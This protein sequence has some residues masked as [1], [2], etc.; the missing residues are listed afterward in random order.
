MCV[1]FQFLGHRSD[2]GQSAM[3][4]YDNRTGVIF[5][6]QVSTN[7]I[8]CWNTAKPLTEKNIGIIARDDTCML[9]PSDINVSVVPILQSP[10]ILQSC[11]RELTPVFQFHADRC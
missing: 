10:I 6:S 3:H 5:F 7:A 8:A 11:A 9:Y 2:L 4:A 1:H